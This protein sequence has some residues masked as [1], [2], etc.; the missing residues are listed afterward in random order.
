MEKIE[1]K[2]KEMYETDRQLFWPEWDKL[3]RCSNDSWYFLYMERA[4]LENIQKPQ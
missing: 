2:A 4:K 1:A 3:S